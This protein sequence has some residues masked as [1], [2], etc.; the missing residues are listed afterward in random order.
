MDQ[1]KNKLNVISI[2]INIM[3]FYYFDILNDIAN[4]WIQQLVTINL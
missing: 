4:T 1:N 2:L 3:I